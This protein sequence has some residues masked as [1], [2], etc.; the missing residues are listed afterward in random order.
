MTGTEPHTW[1]TGLM[2][3]ITYV[4]LDVRNGLRRAHRG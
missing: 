3:T 4:G 2:D 1:E